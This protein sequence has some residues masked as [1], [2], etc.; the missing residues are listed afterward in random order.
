VHRLAA[1]MA[2]QQGIPATRLVS[3]RMLPPIVN[4]LRVNGAIAVL[5]VLVFHLLVLASGQITED[6]GLGYDGGS[7]A[8]MVEGRFSDGSANTAVRPMVILIARIPYAFGLGTIETFRL[9]N[10]VAA[11]VLYLVIG[12]LLEQRSVALP[13]RV[14]LVVNLALT[15]ALS[16]MLAFYPVLVDLGAMALICLAFYLALTDRVWLAA[17]ASIGAAASREFGVAVPLF[18]LHRAIRQRQWVSALLYLPALAVPALIRSPALGI[19]PAE[20]SPLTIGRLAENLRLWADPPFVVAFAYVLLTVFGGVS[21]LLWLRPARVFAAVRREPE[22]LTYSGF[23]LAAAAVGDADIWRYVAYVLPV[24]IV[25]VASA[26][27]DL[28]PVAQSR[29]LAV[30]TLV[31]VITQ[32]PF[33]LMTMET[34]FSDWFPLYRLSRGSAI[35]VDVAATWGPRVAAVI[36]TALALHF[37]IR[38]NQRI[39]A[40]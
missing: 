26:L 11:F 10:Y 27:E 3:S 32:R 6:R 21:M 19:V 17:L 30:V 14:V 12:M 2:A 35:P 25:A 36:L 9:L 5:G 8:R 28:A 4:S 38:R 34:Y 15:I 13:A 7:Y 24:A 20:D 1:A 33:Q 16:K 22:L 29:V 40:A 37:V 23:V 39:A 31:T 18:G